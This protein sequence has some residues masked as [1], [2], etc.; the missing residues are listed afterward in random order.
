MKIITYIATALVAGYAWLV[1]S[2]M[3]HLFNP[4]AA[5]PG[6]QAHENVLKV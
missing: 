4:E 5:P 1:F 3:Y 2:N 6:Q